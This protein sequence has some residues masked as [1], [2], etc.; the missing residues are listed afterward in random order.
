M[1]AIEK[2]PISEIDVA[3]EAFSVNFMPDLQPLRSSIQAVGLIQPVLLK[4]KGDRYQLVCGFRRVEVLRELGAGEIPAMV[5]EETESSDLDLFILSL[6]EHLTTRGLN[7]VEKAIALKKLV[8]FFR[9]GPSEVITTYLPLFSLEPNEKI[10]N[11]YLS[12]AEMEDEIK[13]Y[14]LKEEVSRSN[15]RL[16]A[17]LNPED[18]KTLLPLLSRLKMGE[19]RLREMLTL[20]LEISRRERKEIREVINHPDIQAIF[21]QEELTPT[22]RAERVKKVLLNLRHPRMKQQE[23]AFEKR[24]RALHLPAGLSLHHSPYFEGKELRIEFQFESME[25]YRA[26]VDF[27]S[28]LMDKKEFEE[29]FEVS[30]KSQAPNIK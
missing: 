30:T 20:L 12:L 18:R 23:E 11:T 28:R 10:L 16:L 9:I 17:K 1:K 22:Q 29:M 13:S 21:F 6:Q 15:I 7:A 25:E 24:V 4:R 19:N 14:V 8:Q 5:L 27:L 26:I 3:D 2:I